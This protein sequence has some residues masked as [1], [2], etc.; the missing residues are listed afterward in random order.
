MVK[1]TFKWQERSLDQAFDEL[2]GFLGRVARGIAIE[3]WDFI[4]EETPQFQ[5]RMAASWTFSYDSPIF[6]D[7]SHKVWEGETRVAKNWD[8]FYGRSKGDDRAIGISTYANIGNDNVAKLGVTM[9]ISNGVDHGEGPYSLDV[10][11]G[12]VNLRPVNMPGAPV[13]RAIDLMQSRYGEGVSLWH[14]KVLAEHRI[15]A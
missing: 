13:A 15:A 8:R 11:T 7:R 5:G 1:A 4:L 12:Q 2:E 3:M 9:F 10:E 6:E 14:A